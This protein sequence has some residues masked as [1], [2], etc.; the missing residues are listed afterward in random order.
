MHV[1]FLGGPRKTGKS[2]LLRRLQEELQFTQKAYFIEANPDAEGYWTKA[3]YSRYGVDAKT[4]AQLV[5]KRVEY[6]SAVGFALQSIRNLLRNGYT[7]I[8]ALGGLPSEE[9]RRLISE[10]TDKCT[11]ILLIPS[12][13]EGD[14]GE[15]FEGWRSML[16]SLGVR[17]VEMDA[18]RAYTFIKN[19]VKEGCSLSL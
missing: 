12:T 10:F 11:V 1:F 15:A 7:V 18:E 2:T 6:S 5:K 17:F 16:S 3:W 4:S 9:N 8:C 19:K 13:M 14:I